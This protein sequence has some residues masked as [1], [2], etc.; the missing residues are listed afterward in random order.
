M[1]ASLADAEVRASWPVV[2]PFQ[3][4]FSAPGLEAIGGV[5]LAGIVQPI[6]RQG[7]FGKLLGL[8]M[9]DSWMGRVTRFASV[10]LSAITMWEVGRLLG[11]GNLAKF[12][13]YYALGRGIEEGITKPYILKN[14]PGIPGLAGY[15]SGLGQVRIPDQDELGYL[16]QARI[17]DQDE[18]RG[19]GQRIVTEEELLG[20]VGE[21]GA[22]DEESNVF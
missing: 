10:A 2:G 17:P 12:G 18:L 22:D 21:D 4:L 20:T 9:D 14:I 19:M 13:A 1:G 15:G 7:L 16:A 3:Y 11:S 5:T 8:N 6:I